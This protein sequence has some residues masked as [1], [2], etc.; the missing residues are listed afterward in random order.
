MEIE[1]GPRGALREEPRALSNKWGLADWI[2]A[3]YCCY[4]HI[5][6]RLKCGPCELTLRKRADSEIERGLEVQLNSVL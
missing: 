1:A 3:G 5:H 6:P 2:K 4:Y